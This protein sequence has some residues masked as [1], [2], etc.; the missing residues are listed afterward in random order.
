MCGRFVSSSPPDELAR[1][2]SAAPPEEP[3]KGSNPPTANFNV[4]PTTDI[5]AVFEDGTTRRLEAF[6][7]GL[8]PFWAKDLSV[9]NRMIN[10]RSETLLSSNAYKRP[11]V[12]RRCIIPADGF[13]EWAAVQGHKKKQPYFIHRRDGEPLAFAG[14]WEVWKGPK[15]QE[16]DD[17]ESATYLRSCT[18][19]TTS[20]NDTM[21]PVHN[22]MPVILPPSGWAQWLD[23]E[24]SDTDALGRLL[25][26]APNELLTMHPVSLEVNNVRNGGAHLIEPVAAVDPDG[27]GAPAG[28]SAVGSAE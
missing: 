24:N 15:D 2:F 25:V 14:L 22:R 20:A 17:E 7:W 18:I 12:R 1:Y 11:F 26:P 27:K 23:R 3:A 21:T 6:H 16:T 9:G 4:A 19:I 5:Y 10:A 8:V 13:F 28:P